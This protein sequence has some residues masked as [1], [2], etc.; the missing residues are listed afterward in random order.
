[1]TN[2]RSGVSF[3]FGE[4]EKVLLTSFPKT[5]REEGHLTA[6]YYLTTNF[7]FKTTVK[8]QPNRRLE[9]F[10]SSF[11]S[12]P[13]TITLG[14]NVGKLTLKRLITIVLRG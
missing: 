7:G 5:K 8:H 11:R 14:H 3:F 12:C 1:M 4:S 2:L 10:Y 9:E 13:Q 6:G